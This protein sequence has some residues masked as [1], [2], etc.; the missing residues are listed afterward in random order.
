MRLR[1]SSGG[2]RPGSPK[3]CQPLPPIFGLIL[4]GQILVALAWMDVEL[5][6][7]RMPLLEIN[8]AYLNVC[9]GKS[10]GMDTESDSVSKALWV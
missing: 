6:A 1:G 8:E 7:E 5:R 10:G 2:I 3:I 4:T 9:A